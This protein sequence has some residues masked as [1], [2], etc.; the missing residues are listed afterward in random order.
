MLLC[1]IKTKDEAT[2]EKIFSC[3]K[4]LLNKEAN[5]N[6]VDKKRRTAIM[7]AANNGHLEIVKLLLPL[8]DKDAEDNQNWNVNKYIEWLKKKQSFGRAYKIE[9]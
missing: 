3:V 6:L 4:L 1:N 5:V 9:I 8:V 7:F 2:K